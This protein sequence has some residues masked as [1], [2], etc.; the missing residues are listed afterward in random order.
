MRSVRFVLLMVM[1][2]AV[3]ASAAAQG[4]PT[5]AITGAVV[6]PDNLALPGVTVTATSPSV[7][8]ARTAVTSANG[9]F[10]V[11]FLPAGQYTV[12]FE[13]SGFQSQKQVVNVTMAETLPIRIKLTIAAV[14]ETI[15]VTGQAATEVLTTSTV[16]SNYKADLLHTL[17]VGRALNDAVLLAP[18][19]TPTGPSGNIVMSGALSFESIYLVNGVVINENLRGQALNLVHRGRDPGDQDIH[20]QHLGRIRPVRRRRRQHDHEVGRQHLQRVVPDDAGERRLAVVDPVSDRPDHQQD[21]PC[22]RGNARRPRH[23]GQD[24]VLRRRP[25]HQARGQPDARNHRPQLHEGHRRA[26][27][28]RQADLRAEPAEQ[29]Q[30]LLHEEDDGDDEQR[31][32]PNHGHGQP[33][34]QLDRDVPLHG[35]LHERRDEQPVPRGPVPPRRSARRWTPDRASRTW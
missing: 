28:R 20:R 21:R 19:V 22:L 8:G 7:Q 24:L 10:I 18:G 35:Q 5:G 4:N 1:A 32:R 3:A 13:L 31:V 2:L 23:E 26:A 15:T 34:R 30:G 33:V 12:V 27:L 6:D 9:D 29:R 14:T 16:A 11:P 25:V 17:P